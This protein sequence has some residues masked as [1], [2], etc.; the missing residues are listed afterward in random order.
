[1]HARTHARAHT[2]STAVLHSL[3]HPEGGCNNNEHGQVQ[4]RVDVFCLQA[5]S[6][7]K[8]TIVTSAAVK[9]LTPTMLATIMQKVAAPAKLACKSKIKQT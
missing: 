2:C 5:P 1:M 7:H 6:R 9:R 4:G 8:V 3:A